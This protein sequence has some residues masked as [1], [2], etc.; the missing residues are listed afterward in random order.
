M[1]LSI[2]SSIY[3]RLLQAITGY[4]RNK[5]AVTGP[6]FTAIGN[7]SSMAICAHI[8]LKTNNPTLKTTILPNRP[9]VT[10]TYNSLEN[11]LKLHESPF[12]LEIYDLEIHRCIVGNRSSRV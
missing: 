3:Y 7:V 9:R 5:T 10:G 6:S 2:C 12:L 1:L 4:C 11:K 8:W